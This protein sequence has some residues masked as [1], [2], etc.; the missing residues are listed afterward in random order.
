MARVVVKD[1]V[2]EDPPVARFLFSSTTMAW[3]WLVVR[4]WVGYQ[5]INAALHKIS[6]PAWMQT[7]AALKGFW[8]RAVAIPQ[9]GRPPIA[10]DWYREFI[11]WLLNT[12][13][14]TWF[15][16][17]V[18]YGELLVG[19]ALVLGA[20]VGVA[21]FFG[22]LMNWN[23]MM[24]GAAS[25]NPVLFTLAILLLLAWKVAGY[26]GLDYYLLAWLGTP[27]RPGRIFK[28]RDQN[29]SETSMA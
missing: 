12:Q 16:K 11:R 3:V 13:S 29:Q 4:V 21:A 8:E 7:G 10:F 25:T 9:G 26:I 23:F 28:M 15:A 24:A 6:D 17:L 1:H 27:W 22:A 14:Y 5:W 2:I 19:I 20:F 18:T